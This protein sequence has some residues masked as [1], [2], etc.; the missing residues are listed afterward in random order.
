MIYSYSPTPGKTETIAGAD[1]SIAL[2]QDQRLGLSLASNCRPVVVDP[3]CL[4]RVTMHAVVDLL[5]LVIVEVRSVWSPPTRAGS[6]TFSQ[7]VID[8]ALRPA[9]TGTT[10]F[11]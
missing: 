8:L 3:F 2:S 10:L 6:H 7:G 11:D 5:P 9:D 4:L 1:Y